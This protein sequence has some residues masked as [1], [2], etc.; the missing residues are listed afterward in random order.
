[1][2]PPRHPLPNRGG[3]LVALLKPERNAMDEFLNN[4]HSAHYVY[5]RFLQ[6]PMAYHYAIGLIVLV[7]FTGVCFSIAFTLTEGGNDG[8]KM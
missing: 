4:Y 6:L 3:A 5:L 2:G 8:G 1:M 7:A